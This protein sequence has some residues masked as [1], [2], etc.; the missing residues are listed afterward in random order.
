M[1]SW[2][3]A[4]VGLSLAVALVA[5]PRLPAGPDTYVHLLWTQQVMRCLREVSLPL[6][7]PDLNAGFG[8]PGIRLYSPG[9]PFVAGLLGLLL[10]DAGRGLRLATILALAALWRVAGAERRLFGLWWLANPLLPFL[11]FHRGAFSEL[12]ALPLALWLLRAH[13]QDTGKNPVRAL[14]WA[15]LWLVHAPT[16][17]TVTLL[18]PLAVLGRRSR[19]LGL[20]RW[21]WPWA[22]GLALTAWHW[23]PLLQEQA[24]VAAKEGLTG[25]IFEYRRNFLASP[26]AHDWPAVAALSW[27]AVSWLALVLLARQTPGPRLLALM[28]L[29]L[30]APISA[31]FWRV[32]PVLPWLQFPWRFLTPASLLLPEL[33]PRLGRRQLCLA[34]LLYLGPHLWLPS[35]QAVGDPRLAANDPWWVLGGK[36]HQELAGNPLVVD[37]Q[38]NRP[39]SFAFLGEQLVTFGKEAALCPGPCQ[40]VRWRPLRRELAVSGPGGLVRLRLLAYP[41]WRA[42][43]DGKPAVLRQERGVIAV[44]VDPGFHRLAV[45]WA[46]NPRSR[47]GWALALAAVGVLVVGRRSGKR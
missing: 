20:W 12:Y 9:G 21:A 10:A 25:G 19:R 44:A 17:V 45:T 37:A 14:G 16:F 46:G 8:S 24:W 28:C 4:L 30:A 15:A 31:P 26:A 22:L 3:A 13:W 39:A 6:W 38:Q 1:G 34:V 18:T 29:F 41:L 33:L 5:W 42:T 35:W 23:L 43:V 32:L 2:L 47:W 27:L 36:V 40:V 7:L 11:I